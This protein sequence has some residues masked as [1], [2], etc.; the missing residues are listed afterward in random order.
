MFFSGCWD[1]CY[2]AVPMGHFSLFQV[3]VIIV[4]SRRHESPFTFSCEDYAYIVHLTSAR[5]CMRA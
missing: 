4:R 3:V 2:F 1:N 5:E